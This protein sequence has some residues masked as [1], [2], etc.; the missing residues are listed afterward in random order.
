MSL[1]LET[2]FQY[3]KTRHVS[4]ETNKTTSKMAP[5][6]KTQRTIHDDSTSIGRRF[7]DLAKF[8]SS[9]KGDLDLANVTAPPFFLAPSSVVENPGSWAQRPCLFTAPTNELDPAKRSLSVLQL[10]LAGLR[11]QLYVAG[12]PN[13]S[14]KKP[15]N[16]FLGEQFLASWSEGDSN[17]RLVVE[18]VSHH[19]P[20]TAMHI[21]SE[22][23]RADGYGRVEMTFNGNINIRQMGHAIIHLDR[24]D[25]DYLVPLTDVTVRGF[26]SA[27]LYPEIIGTYTIN[28][29]SG[30]VS[31]IDFS[32]TGFFRGK[33]NSFEARVYHKDQPKK[34]CYKVSGVW[35]EGWKITDANGLVETYTVEPEKSSMNMN[36]IEKQDP[37]ESRRAW[38]MSF[39]LCS[40]GIIEM[41]LQR[42]IQ[43]RKPNGKRGKKKR[44]QERYG[45]QLYLIVFRERSMTCF[46]GCQKVRSGNFMMKRREE[47]GDLMRRVCVK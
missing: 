28:S 27:C 3:I 40:K 31:E 37:R 33:R 2:Q 12:A 15:L 17:T 42:S 23:I 30:Y 1:R 45:S 24:F 20:I 14:I 29:S 5:I 39:Q 10:F 8:L 25:E 26:M 4:I 19:P 38:G 43:W 22:G 35:S 46:I 13:V 9:L 36:P 11:S 21:A 18:Q 32:G 44:L 6:P 34:I 41:H 47:F 7:V 16:A